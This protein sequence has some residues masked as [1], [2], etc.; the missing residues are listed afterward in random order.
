[1]FA[2]CV[3][4]S[5]LDCIGFFFVY[6]LKLRLRSLPGVSL[7]TDLNLNEIWMNKQ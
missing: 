7:K 2:F 3:H 1:M 6:L 4:L 5:G